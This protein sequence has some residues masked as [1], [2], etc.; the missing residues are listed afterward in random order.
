MQHYTQNTG[1]QMLIRGLCALIIINGAILFYFPATITR[2]ILTAMFRGVVFISDN[3]NNNNANI[4]INTIIHDVCH[5]RAVAVHQCHNAFSCNAITINTTLDLITSA[6]SVALAVLF[7]GGCRYNSDLLKEIM[8]G[9]IL[10]GICYI[11][12]SMC[13]VRPELEG[14]LT[15][16]IFSLISSAEQQYKVLNCSNT[17]LKNILSCCIIRQTCHLTSS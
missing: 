17:T 10:A 1:L 9:Y 11:T 6:S 3:T 15:K 7:C 2:G 4:E 12:F 8:F 13:I 16:I 14:L 5:K